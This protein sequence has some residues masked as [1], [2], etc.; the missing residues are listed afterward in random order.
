MVNISAQINT[1]YRIWEKKA[2][3][4]Q[5]CTKENYS[6]K[7]E[8]DNFIQFVNH[9]NINNIN[10]QKKT[11]FRTNRII[12]ILIIINKKIIKKKPKQQVIISLKQHHNNNNNIIINNKLI[13]K[14]LDK[15]LFINK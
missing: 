14:H 12:S 6:P 4:L 13:T 2:L 11:N 7:T 15:V 3:Q 9:N 10:K 8:K 1:T 5:R